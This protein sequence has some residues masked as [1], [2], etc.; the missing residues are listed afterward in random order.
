L[1]NEPFFRKLPNG[2]DVVVLVM[3]T[4]GIFDSQST[5]TDC[6]TVFALSTMMSSIQVTFSLFSSFLISGENR[7]KSRT[8]F[9][10]YNLSMNIRENDL[11]HLQLS[12]EY[13]RMAMVNSPQAKP[14]QKLLFLVRDWSSPRQHSYGLDGEGGLL[15]KRLEVCVCQCVR[16]L[17]TLYSIS[18]LRA[19]SSL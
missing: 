4:Q 7:K 3:D 2:D 12:T 17:N 13:G 14:F 16:Y 19:F 9:Q 8:F 15:A 1:W 6:A 10:V 18:E 5:G 11:Q